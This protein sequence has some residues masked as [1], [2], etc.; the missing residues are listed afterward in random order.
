[1]EVP[2]MKERTLS[3]LMVMFGGG[4][5]AATPG[6][7]PTTALIGM[8]LMMWGGMRLAYLKGKE[9]KK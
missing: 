1:M 7:T 2:E 4:V 8:I 6:L 9:A 5:W 3:L